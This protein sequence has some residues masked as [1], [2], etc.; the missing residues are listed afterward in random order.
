[1][2]TSPQ[3]TSTP[4]LGYASVSTANTARDGSGTIVDAFTAGASGARVERVVL[5]ATDNPADSVV[6]MFIYDGSGYRL[7]DEFDLGDPAAASTTAEGYRTSRAY[8]DLILEAGQK[9][10]FAITV[11]LTGGVINAFV[12]GGDF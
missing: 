2:G 12:H 7:Y 5:K 1:M 6:T 3:F 4:N 10:A 9:I 8:E 11:A